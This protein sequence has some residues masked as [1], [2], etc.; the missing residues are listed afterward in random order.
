[1]TIYD[2][3][4]EDEHQN[5]YNILMNPSKILIDPLQSGIS[6]ECQVTFTCHVKRGSADSTSN[7]TYDMVKFTGYFR[8]LTEIPFNSY[9]KPQT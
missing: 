9:C 8:K 4:H 7:V 5:I 3:V 6:S 2:I 1:M